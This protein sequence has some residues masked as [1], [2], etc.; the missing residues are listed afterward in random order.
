MLLD[1]NVAIQMGMLPYWPPALIYL[2][3]IGAHH[4][5]KRETQI[6]RYGRLL[7]QGVLLTDNAIEMFENVAHILYGAYI[8]FFFFN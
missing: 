3:Y 8:C 2:I 4:I 7:K 5:E 6:A 1:G